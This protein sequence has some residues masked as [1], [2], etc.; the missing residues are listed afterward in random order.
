MGI[1]SILLAATALILSTSVNSA[2]VST[3]WQNAGDN[4]ITL[5]TVSGLEWLDLTE[6]SS[7]SYDDVTA[8]LGVGGAYE[9]FR[10]ATDTEV[11]S[12]W[13]N[14]GVD[15]SQDAPSSPYHIGVTV[16]PG[17]VD[18][19]TILKNYVDQGA[20]TYRAVGITGTMSLPNY[21]AVLGA[22]FTGFNTQHS[23]YY[24]EGHEDVFFDVFRDQRV[25]TVGSYLVVGTPTTVPVP[26]A[27][28]LF[29]SGLIGLVGFAR[30]KKA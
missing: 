17:I 5:D 28:W 16:D 1:K 19:A 30:R 22:E 18:A 6:T 15:L 8:Q 10:Y 21:Y 14:F 3:D 2:I 24:E 4:L 26:A 23:Y 12:L 11:I 25:N 7:M 27:V 29:G 13:S 9:G 20:E